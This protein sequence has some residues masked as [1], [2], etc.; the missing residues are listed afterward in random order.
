VN[1]LQSLVIGRAIPT[2][3]LLSQDIV[4]LAFDGTQTLVTTTPGHDN[5]SLVYDSLRDYFYVADPNL[6]GQLIRVQLPSGTQTNIGALQR[7]T[8]GEM[9][10]SFGRDAIFAV[11]FTGSPSDPR[12]NQLY[13]INTTGGLAP[14]SVDNVGKMGGDHQ[15]LGIAFAVVPEPTSLLLFVVA[16]SLAIA[17]KRGM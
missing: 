10:Y 4:K 7:P 14:I 8:M 12:F 1:S 5:D 15:V 13:R 2:N 9:A 16:L 17:T 6:V 11:D 3:L